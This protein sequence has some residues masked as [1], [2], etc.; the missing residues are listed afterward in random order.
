MTEAEWLSCTDFNLLREWVQR[1]HRHLSTER[2]WR[3]LNCACF[4][5]TWHLLSESSREAV[6]LAERYA[7]SLVEGLP[8]RSIHCSRGTAVLMALSFPDMNALDWDRAET[9]AQSFERNYAITLDLE[10]EDEGAVKCALLREILRNPFHAVG[11]NPRWCTSS[12]VDLVTAIHQE[13]A[14]DRMPILADAL[15]DAGCDNERIIAHCRGEGS[16]V[17]GCWVVDLLLGK[18]RAP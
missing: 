10:G 1:N 4:R 16:H 6:E 3:L 11:L 15:M 5:R 17:R 8:K 9:A 14:F 18:E 12:V 2:K 13:K 7:D